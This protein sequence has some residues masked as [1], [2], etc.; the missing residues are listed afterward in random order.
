[1]STILDEA[2]SKAVT[3][4]G[5]QALTGELRVRFRHHVAPGEALQ[6]RGWIVE[7]TRRLI[8]T[9]GTLAAADGVE[10]AHAWAVFLVLKKEEKSNEDC[11]TH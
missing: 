7:R 11:R 4:S 3:A 9:E 1:M 5:T 8:R 6:I 2:M 10:R